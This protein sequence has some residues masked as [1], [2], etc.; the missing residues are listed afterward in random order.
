MKNTKGAKDSSIFNSKD[1][2]ANAKK[3]LYR[4]II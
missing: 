2:K 1:N 4:I 3:R